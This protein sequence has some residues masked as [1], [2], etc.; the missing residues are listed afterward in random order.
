MVRPTRS[1]TLEK[2]MTLGNIVRQKLSETPAA[3]ARH[4]LMAADEAGGWT[5]YL[6]A[7]R[8]DAWTTVAW[9]VSLRRPAAT[10]DLASW[11]ERI[12]QRSSGLLESL[13]VVEVDRT[14]VRELC[15]PGPILFESREIRF[16]RN[17]DGDGCAPQ[18]SQCW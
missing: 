7:E 17:G 9:E 2:A 10:G 1:R 13:R 3:S 4:E 14:R 18:S 6:T 5:V 11:A 16:R 15:K 8:R 12:A